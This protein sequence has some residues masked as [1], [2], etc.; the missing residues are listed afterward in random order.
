MNLNLC[1]NCNVLLL[2]R[3]QHYFCSNNCQGEYQYKKYI[4]R[5]KQGFVSGQRGIV[6]KNVSGHVIRYLNEKYGE[7]CTLC[8]WEIKHSISGK[9]P[10]EIDH[11]DG[12]ADNNKESNL[13]LIC[14][15]CHALTLNFRNRNRG[16]GRMW[17]KSK[18]SKGLQ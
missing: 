17:R 18:Y 11:I 3:R 4:V 5:W 13:R 7:K 12:N 9:V 2:K 8:G 15:N 6:T 10:L 1:K 14:P 16:K